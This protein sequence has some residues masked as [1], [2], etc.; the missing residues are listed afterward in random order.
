[1]LRIF[2]SS[3]R[4]F[5]L[6]GRLAAQ[7]PKKQTHALTLH[8][9]L[10][11]LRPPFCIVFVLPVLFVLLAQRHTTNAP[12]QGVHFFPAGVATLPRE[13]WNRRTRTVPARRKRPMLLLLLLVPLVLPLPPLLLPVLPLPEL[14]PPHHHHHHPQTK[15]KTR[16]SSLPRECAS[17][18]SGTGLVLPGTHARE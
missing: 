9:L 10:S 1:M 4:F 12:A 13:K 5:D 16:A 14:Q 15:T 3:C 2:R 6:A 18:S 11:R 17:L 7:L 8:L